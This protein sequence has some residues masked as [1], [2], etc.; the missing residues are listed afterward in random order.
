MAGT[1]R[2]DSQD[3]PK[4]PGIIPEK[5]SGEKIRRDFLVVF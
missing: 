3:Q 2:R 1:P 5:V 4:P